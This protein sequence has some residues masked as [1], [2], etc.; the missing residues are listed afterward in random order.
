MKKS[1]VIA[2]VFLLA[3]VASAQ[4]E[5][6]ALTFTGSNGSGPYTGLIQNAK[7]NFYGATINGGANGSGTVYKLTRNAK[8]K[9]KQTILYDFGPQPGS[10]GAY[11]QMPQLAIDKHGH[12]YGTTPNGGPNGHGMVFELSSGKPMW[13]ETILYSFTGGSDGGGPIGG[14]TLDSNGNVYGT[15]NVGG[16]SQN[17]GGGC[18]VVF[19]LSPGKK[20]TW[21][22]SVLHAFTGYPPGGGCANYDG[23]NPY[24]AT[25]AIDTV[26][27][28]FGTTQLGG[29]GCNAAGTVWEL[30][31][32]HGGGWDYS[33]LHVQGEL[34][35]DDYPDAGVAL[36]SQDNL[37]FAVGGGSIFE[38]VKGQGYQ[39]EV[40]YQ[41][42][43]P[44]DEDDYDTVSFD[45]A[46]NL[47]WT[48]QGG[49]GQGYHGTVEELSPDGQG[50]W[51]HTYLWAFSDNPPIGGTQP[52]AGVMIDASGNLY[53]TCSTGGGT[54][55][56]YE[57]GTVWEITP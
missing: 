38:L 34:V 49:G 57:N 19:E 12:L 25:L 48:S 30:S 29:N 1:Y 9:W 17:C 46:G 6:T 5:E 23:A 39:E 4:T 20:K 35:G 37:Y 13:K 56:P 43:G 51:T 55:Y 47:Y 44:G 21:N 14:V 27:N 50:G 52:I 28:V 10:D 45:K 33:V 32:E 40:I 16:G 24:R 41:Y 26:G 7:G 15:T 2:L 3:A 31:P 42:P 53:G 54:Q 18:G 36:D 8:G 11:P 22:Y